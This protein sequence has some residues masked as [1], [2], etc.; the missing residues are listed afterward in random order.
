MSIPIG[1][2]GAYV[3]SG[4]VLVAIA[5]KLLPLLFKKVNGRNNGNGKPGKAK[6]C[7]ESGK[8][9]AGHEILINQLC[10]NQDKAE[11]SAETARKENREDHKQIF[12]KLD[13]LK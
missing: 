11:K 2:A 6:I 5:M 1:E 4:G 8:L 12:A 9:L 7:I 10:A 3:G 13:E